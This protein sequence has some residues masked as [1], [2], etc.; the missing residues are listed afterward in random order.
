MKV[1]YYY[2]SLL[3]CSLLIFNSCSDFED[4]NKNPITVGEDEVKIE[5][6][7]N[8][9]VIDAQM[10]SHIAE[11]L[12]ILTWK[13]GARFELSQGGITVCDDNNEWMSDYWNY[14]TN[15]LNNASLAIRIGNK[16]IEEDTGYGYTNN[17]VQMA[18]I[19]RA[20]LF[21]EYCDNYG[22][23]PALKAFMGENPSYDSVESVY[24]YMLSELKDA[25]SKLDL[26]Q[27]VNDQVKRQDTFYNCDFL[28]WKKYGNSLRLRFAMRLSEVDPS[29]AKQAFEDAI[30][31]AQGE[32]GFISQKEDIAW[33][34]EKNSGPLEGVMSRPWNAQKV[35]ATY[36]NLTLG[37]GGITSSQLSAL[38]NNALSKIPEDTLTMYVKNINEYIGLYLPEHLPTATNEPTAGY[39]FDGI[40]N[41]I[42]PR[43]FIVFCLPGY[44]DG[45]VYHD[46]GKIASYVEL[47]RSITDPSTFSVRTKFTW[48]AFCAGSWGQKG[49]IMS[50]MIG[51]NENM[52]RVSRQYREH[53]NRR[54]FFGPWETYFLL[55]EASCY[56]WSTGGSAE[57][58]YEKGV[59]ASFDYHSIPQLAEEY[60]KSTEYNRIGTSVAFG[61]TIEAENYTISYT[62]GYTGKGGTT[63]YSYPKNFASV[64]NNDILTKIFTQKYIAQC[65]YLPLEAWSDHRRKG[66]PFL[67]NPAV[68]NSLTYMPWLTKA[69]VKESN[70]KNFP[71]R[72]RYPSF[73]P[74]NN[75]EGYKQA[76]Q[77]L[78]GEDIVSTSLWWNKK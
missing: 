4:V 33:V 24:D 48:G 15:W 7:F 75:A 36:S 41:K 76:M 31:D 35:S 5:Y 29:K 26:T 50:K 43:A 78:G 34:A 13:E 67:E 30:S 66:L 52:P 44:N 74:V 23:V 51:E 17:L 6:L 61:H 14:L 1:L 18:R 2:I 57:S 63:T 55:A 8:N 45:I 69:N 64:T 58:Y 32:N 3:L 40:P 53:S 28:K 19:W 56:G 49:D 59:R 11:R 39:F 38:P 72:V 25:V 68:E 71:K 46:Q 16:Q 10:D 62:D 47:P 77:Y 60:L 54:V 73:V 70:V 12:F 65:P 20:Y 9:S 27:N 37:L 22:P 21:S 42:D